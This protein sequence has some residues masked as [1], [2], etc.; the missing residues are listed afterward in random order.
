[1]G[2]SHFRAHVLE[3]DISRKILM[4]VFQQV[5]HPLVA[6]HR[7]AHVFV[8]LSQ[9]E[10]D[11]LG[12]VAAKQL[13]VLL[14]LFVIFPQHFEKERTDLSRVIV[15]N[16]AG[17]CGLQIEIIAVDAG[18]GHQILKAAAILQGGVNKFRLEQNVDHLKALG[19]VGIVRKFV[20]LVVVDHKIVSLPH[21]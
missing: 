4:D 6:V 11:D 7:I 17:R 19:V 13:A 5:V 16:E 3:A 10:N 18:V 15:V 2:V 12:E 8:D 21:G 9:G 1:M 14:L 20:D